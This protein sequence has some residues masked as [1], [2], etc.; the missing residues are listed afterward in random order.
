[1]GG[2]IGFTLDTRDVPAH[3]HRGIHVT[4]EGRLVPAVWDVRRTYA[5]TR[6]VA[7]A[8]QSADVPLQPTLAVRV[9]GQRNVGTVP[10]QESAFLG[11]EGSVRGLPLQRYAGAASAFGNAELRVDLV[12]TQAIFPARWGGYAGADAGRVWAPGTPA[13]GWHRSVGG[14]AWVSFL[15]R[16][17]SARLGLARSADE[18]SVY[19]GAGL[20]F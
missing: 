2:R 9:G 5:I 12:G 19:V 20:P 16:A 6:L 17:Y 1:L 14:G 13:G 4:G 10:F 8:Y 18:T 11:G 3:A 7:S 15:D